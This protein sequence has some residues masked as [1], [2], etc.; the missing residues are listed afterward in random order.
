[1]TLN[2]YSVFDNKAGIYARPFFARDDA[3]AIRAFAYNGKTDNF[4]K[5]NLADYDLFKLGSFDDLSGDISID[6][7]KNLANLASLIKEEN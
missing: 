5:S 1:M 4:M 7:R 2:I 3:E 6:C